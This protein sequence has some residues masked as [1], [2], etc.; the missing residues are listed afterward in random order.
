MCSRGGQS[1]G[2]LHSD[3]LP[4]YERKK[5][6][7]YSELV[8]LMDEVLLDVEKLLE[9]T[10]PSEEELQSEASTDDSASAVFDFDEY[11]TLT[12]ESNNLYAV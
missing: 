12:T 7:R 4:G 1:A 6:K 5:N 9:D 8:G 10:K 3:F 2:C 11:A